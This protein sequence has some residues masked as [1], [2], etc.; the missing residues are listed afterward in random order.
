MFFWLSQAWATNYCKD[1]SIV[2][3][4]LSQTN[5]GT[6]LIDSSSNGFNGTFASSGHPAWQT[7]SPTRNYLT[8]SLSWSQNSWVNSGTNDVTSFKPGQAMSFVGWIYPTSCTVDTN[9]GVARITARIASL[10]ATIAIGSVG[11]ATAAIQLNFGGT[12]NL[13]VITANNT[14][15]PNTWA[16]L[17]MTWDGSNTATNVHFYLN[18]IETTYQ[19]Q[20]NGVSLNN[21]STGPLY[22]GNNSNTNREFLGNLTEMAYFKRVLSSAEVADIFNNGLLGNHIDTIQGNSII[23]GGSII[24]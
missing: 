12:T 22:I 19:L 16:H 7:F 4:Y 23:Q 18:G 15:V 8:Y 5:S 20:Q 17:V 14:C 21:T 2:S 11:S 9:V 10:E 24:N 6:T 1:S 13:S 3:C